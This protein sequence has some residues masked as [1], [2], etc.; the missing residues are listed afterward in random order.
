MQ[1]NIERTDIENSSIPLGTGWLLGRCMEGRGRQELYTNQLPEVLNA[2]LEQAIVQSVESSN[3]IEGISTSPAR[4]V[5]LLNGDIKPIERPDLELLGYK[6][7]LNFIYTS[8]DI[9]LN[10]NFILTLHSMCCANSGHAGSFKTTNNDIIEILP[11]GSRHVRFTPA[12]SSDTPALTSRLVSAYQE[13]KLPPLLK[14]ATFIFDFLCVHPFLDGNG[15]VSRLL[16][17]AL[18]L[19]EGFIASRYISLERLVEERKEEYYETLRLCSQGWH[20]GANSIT[21][22]W[23]FFLSILKDAYKAFDDSVKEQDV[24]S[25]KSE[26]IRRNV[27]SMTGSFTLAEVSQKLPSISSS[28]VK[29]I[30]AEL[31]S[32]GALQQF[33]VGRGSRYSVNG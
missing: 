14:V 13:S 11:D 3:R 19:K 20:D 31:K 1:L 6:K 5:S 12:S 2:L 8:D 24:K 4:L 28:L 10:T 29:K 22:W 17:T 9:V 18:L 32:E 25:P 15:R 16:T 21:E 23:G 27:L 30:L 33:G 26:L 7:A